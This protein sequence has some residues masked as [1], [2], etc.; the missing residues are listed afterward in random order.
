LFFWDAARCRLVMCYWHFRTAC[1]WIFG[2][3]VCHVG[4]NQPTLRNDTKQQRFLLH[5]SASLKQVLSRYL[6]HMR[7]CMDSTVIKQ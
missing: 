6:E 5:R 1:Q 4:N 7:I 2:K 3:Y